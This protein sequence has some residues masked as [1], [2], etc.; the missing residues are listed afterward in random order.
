MSTSCCAI[1]Y[2]AAENMM[3]VLA[4]GH[5]KSRMR[6]SRQWNALSQT[7]MDSLGIFLISTV[8]YVDAASLSRSSPADQLGFRYSS[9]Q[10]LSSAYIG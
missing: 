7:C 3:K 8:H 10:N 4:A 6:I 1:L 2:I 5:R 9:K